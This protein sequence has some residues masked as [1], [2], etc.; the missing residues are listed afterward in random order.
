VIKGA[1]NLETIKEILGQLPD[2]MDFD[3]KA[4]VLHKY[5]FAR[6]QLVSRM[7]GNP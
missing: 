2:P 7:G 4:D 6:D 5:G 3:K 1:G